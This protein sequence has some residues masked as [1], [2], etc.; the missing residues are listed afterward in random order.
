MEI[1]VLGSGCASCQKLYEVV[2]RAVAQTGVSAN[3]QKVEDFQEIMSYGVLATPAVA[4]NGKVV[5]AGKIPD[6][7]KVST[8]LTTA[9]AE[10]Q[11][12]V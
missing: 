11:G 9:A 2:E 4:I 12:A 3:L 7:S 1:R 6:V 10:E 8:W 5:S